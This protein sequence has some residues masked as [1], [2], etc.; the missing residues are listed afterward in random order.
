[1]RRL[2]QQLLTGTGKANLVKYA[3]LSLLSGFWGFLI[4]SL[5]TQVISVIMANEYT[6]FSKEY[7]LLFSLVILFFI[8]TRKT[9]STAIIGLSQ[10]MF[11]TI[12]KQILSLILRASYE[13]LNSRKTKIYS[14]MVNDVNTLTN[15]SMSII[16]FLSACILSLSGLIYLA[17][18]SLLL[19]FITL[20]VAVL[21]IMIYQV[22]SRKNVRNFEKARNLEDDFIEHFNSILNGF[23]EIYMEPKKGA[24]IYDDKIIPIADEAYAGNKKAF[25]G[26]LNIQ[27]TGQVLFY[28][29][30][31]SILLF[32]SLILNIK[33]SDTVSFVFTL[34]YLLGS[35]E[36]IMVLLPNIMRANVSSDRLMDLKNELE[37]AHFFNPIAGHYI[38]REEFNQVQIRGLEFQ[39]GDKDKNFSIGPIHFEILKGETA[40]IYGGNGSGKTT[41]INTLLG[42]SKPSQGTIHSNGELVTDGNYPTYRTLF[43]VVFNDFYLFNELLGIE[44]VNVERWNYY[45]ELFELQDKVKLEGKKLSTTDLSTGQR[46]RLALIVALQEE[47]PILVL[48]EWAADQDPYFRKKFYT[49]ILPLLKKENLTII[50]ITHD[51]K[52][53]HCADKLFKMEEGKLKEETVH[54]YESNLIA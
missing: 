17:S 23:K 39:Y 49:H 48:D 40:F 4:M 34:L 1:M 21:G 18:I 44:H 38:K 13:Q 31:S 52:Y 36:T 25:V 35:I 45:I 7:V 51:D 24:V 30:I 11:W 43:S 14:V 15:A 42:I 29:L 10:K 53:Y 3:I 47:K 26:F 27:N 50:A 16:D 8:W 6:L 54:A 9:L 12:R 22:G 2:Y 46:K 37:Q 33:S 32:F 19:F 41:F 28:I 5:V 20:V